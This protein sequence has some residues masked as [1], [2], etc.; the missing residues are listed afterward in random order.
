[1]KLYGGRIVKQ[2][3]QRRISRAQE[4]RDAIVM[5]VDSDNKYCLVRIQGSDVNIKAFYPENW[6]QTPVYLKPGNAVRIT[7]VGGSKS[8]IEVSGH[9]TVRPTDTSSV[10]ITPTPATL[11]DT[12]ISNASIIP[13]NPA[14]MSVMVLNG[15]IRIK[16]VV[17]TLSG[18]LMDD[19]LTTMDRFDLVMDDVGGVVHFDAASA[20]YYRYDS[21]VVGEDLVIEVVK[22]DNFS[23]TTDPI[24]DPPEA[25]TF[26]VRLGWVLIPPNL[27]QITA[28]HIN[29]IYTP[30]S[31]TG[32]YA[33]LTDDTLSWGENTT[34]LR[35]AVLD[36]YG[37]Y[38]RNPSPGWE[39]TIEWMRGTGDL[40]GTAAPDAL[41]TY[42][43]GSTYKSIT[44]TRVTGGTEESPNLYISALGVAGKNMAHIQLINSLGEY[45]P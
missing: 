29:K 13:A 8:R 41:V 32:V 45:I 2:N 38:F 25:P 35:L 28:G 7:T 34:T 43:T 42:H 1:M 26:H 37:N 3:T 36:Q 10:K 15:T 39:F 44:Y 23:T 30:P 4:L 6:E 11:P 33:Y 17:Y 21:I 16:E 5:S 31:A 19:S 12:V 22:G 18:L 40:D 14:D 20:T 27:T 24:P 9:G